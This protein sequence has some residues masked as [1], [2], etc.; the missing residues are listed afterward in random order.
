[1]RPGKGG[2]GTVT[3]DHAFTT[4]PS[5]EIKTGLKF[6]ILKQLGLPKD[7]V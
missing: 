1:M 6:A 3:V 2:H 4:I 5:G 7:I